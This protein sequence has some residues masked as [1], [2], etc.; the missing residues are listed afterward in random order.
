MSRPGPTNV[1]DACAAEWVAWLDYPN[2]YRSQFTLTD[3][4]AD[5]ARI[6]HQRWRETV[7]AQQRMIVKHCAT[8]HAAA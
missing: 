2:P 3:K 8:R 7:T 4:P 5:M 6:N 1:C